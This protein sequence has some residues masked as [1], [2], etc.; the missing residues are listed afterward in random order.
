[1]LVPCLRPGDIVIMDNLGSHKF[2]A[3]FRKRKG[4]RMDISEATPPPDRALLLSILRLQRSHRG[5][6]RSDCRDG[7]LS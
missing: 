2:S 1:L 5:Y 3:E 7:R 6:S 4:G